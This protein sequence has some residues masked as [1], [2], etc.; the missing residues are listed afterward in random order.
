[1]TRGVW[2]VEN[3]NFHGNILFEWP[4]TCLAIY[5]SN[6]RSGQ[7]MNDFV[8]RFEGIFM[9]NLWHISA[10]V[11]IVKVIFLLSR[12]FVNFP[13]FNAIS[14]EKVK[15]FLCFAPLQLQLS[16]SDF[17]VHNFCKKVNLFSDLFV[18]N[19]KSK[20]QTF[21]RFAPLA[22]YYMFFYL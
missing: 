15:Y 18:H 17:L 19:L 5:N 8:N 21:R 11:D 14:I 20:R 16:M 2:G 1:M 9:F 3:W 7:L 4:L 6:I 10:L 22:S 13:S 12:Q